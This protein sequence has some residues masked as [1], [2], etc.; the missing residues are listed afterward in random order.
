MIIDLLR[1]FVY[2]ISLNCF[3]N[4]MESMLEELGY[5]SLTECKLAYSAANNLID[6]TTLIT[7]QHTIKYST[8]CDGK[9]KTK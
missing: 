2:I 5:K 1:S 4:D 3:Y 9:N 8:S 6:Q 7:E